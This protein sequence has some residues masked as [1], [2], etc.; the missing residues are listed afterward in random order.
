M[1]HVTIVLSIICAVL[2]AALILLYANTRKDAKRIR[3]LSHKLS[4]KTTECETFKMTHHRDH[5][6][7]MESRIALLCQ[8]FGKTVSEPVNGSDYA[9]NTTHYTNCILFGTPISFIDNGPMALGVW[10]DPEMDAANYSPDKKGLEQLSSPTRVGL[11]AVL[12]TNQYPPMDESDRLQ[13]FGDLDSIYLS[14]K[15]AVK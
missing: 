8:V 10:Y 14:L 9:G 6:V 1:A 13:R 3:S 7:A 11:R 15:V 2:T 5:R 4:T 12:A